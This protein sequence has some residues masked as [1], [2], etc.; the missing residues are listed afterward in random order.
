MGDEDHGPV[1]IPGAFCSRGYDLAL[2]LRSVGPGWRGLVEP[3][4]DAKPDAVEIVQVKEK[5]AEGSEIHE[6]CGF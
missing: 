2:A 1:R 3:A 4:F 6:F 5:F